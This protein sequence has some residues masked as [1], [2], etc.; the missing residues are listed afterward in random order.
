[1]RV[2]KILCVVAL[3]LTACMYGKAED[4]EAYK[5][6]A[7]LLGG[8]YINNEQAWQLEPSV[9]WHFH[10]YIGVG[11]GMEFTSQYNQPG[12]QTTIDGY[13]ADLVDN[14]RNVS[15][16]IFK[17]SVIFRSPAVW[18][19]SDEYLHIWFQAEPGMS[20]ACPIRNSLTYGIREFQG[21]A[22]H[23]VDY[24]RFP[25]NGLQ[26]FYWNVRASVN[27]AIDRFIIGAGYSISNLDYYSGRRNVT[28]A[29]GQK[30]YVPEKELSQS[31]FLSLGY[32]F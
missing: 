22:G 15:W 13:E 32:I 8:L 10:K 1:M 9:S 2:L 21:M 5:W 23:I 6:R 28:L 20:L 31:I 4:S 27:F 29:N 25:N 7:S 19:S 17:P 3:M 26:W 18:K 12:R 16:I 24:R 30:F 14:E 11:I